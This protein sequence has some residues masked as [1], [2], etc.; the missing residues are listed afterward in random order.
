MPKYINTRVTKVIIIV[1]KRPCDLG[2]VNERGG[3][4]EMREKWGGKTR[5]N[6]RFPHVRRWYPCLCHL[7]LLF[8]LSS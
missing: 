7:K 1:R 2:G 5:V 4:M 3:E 8:S 6:S